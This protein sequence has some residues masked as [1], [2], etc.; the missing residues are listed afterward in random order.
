MYVVQHG[1]CIRYVPLRF[2]LSLLT[3]IIFF[4][5]LDP[6]LFY[7]IFLLLRYRRSIDF[8]VLFK[9]VTK[10]LY[11]DERSLYFEQRFISLHDGFV[12]AVALCKNTCVGGTVT[13]R[14]LGIV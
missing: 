6:F 14:C 7:Q 1:A 10:L 3:I 2:L 9:L 11:W 8:L 13:V 12:R 5:F 4:P